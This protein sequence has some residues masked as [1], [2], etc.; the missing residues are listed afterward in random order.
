MKTSSLTFLFLFL[1]YHLYLPQINI[2]GQPKEGFEERIISAVNEIRIIDTHEH[3]PTEEERLQ[4]PQSIDF[5]FLFRHYAKE[6]LISAINDKSF[7]E[8][9]YRT[10]FSL[11]DR[12]ELFSPLYES[13]GNTSYLKVAQIAARDLFGVP[14]ISGETIEDLSIKMKNANKPGWYEKVLKDK[15]KI[16]LSIM[17]MG[18]K[19]FDNNYYRHVERFDQYIQISSKAE[20]FGYGNQQNISVNNLS[21]YEI[22][23][24]KYFE[25]GIE[26]GM[27]GVK[28]GLAYS[29]I[30]RFNNVPKIK[31]EVIFNKLLDGSLINQEEIKTL[32]DYLMHSVLK[33]VDEY[34]IPIQI[35]TG[36]QAGNG[37]TIT[38]SNPTHLSNLFMEYP[39]IDFCLFHG[40]Y[41]YGGELSTLAKNFPNVF[42]DMCWIYVIS[43]SYSERYLHEWLETVPVSKIMAFGGDYNFVEGVYAHSVMAREIVSNV[44][45]E[46]VRTGYF[47]EEEAVRA[48]VKILRDNA[49]RI[50]KIEG[51]SKPLDDLKIFN[52][53]GPIRDWWQI[54]NSGEG[55]VRNWKVI[56][57]FE[58]GNGLDTEYP[59]EEEIIFEK[60]YNGLVEGV[61]WN[62]E[63]IPE[64]GYLN[65]I[66]VFSR[67]YENIN[68]RSKGIA[69]AY[70]EIV[71][72]DE[73]EVKIT[74]G[75]NDG[76]KIWVNGK[77]VYNLHVG[78]N[79]VPDQDVLNV[80]LKKGRNKFLIKVENLG[81]NWGLFLR[82]IDPKKALEF[83]NF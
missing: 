71:S 54:H 38:N 81:A 44:L 31:A 63:V 72:P 1:S 75:S 47:S 26:Y 41:P 48:A 80:N 13:A 70:T 49:L 24:R 3:L 55:F 65:F 82:I 60:T 8:L 22:V 59:V 43:P 21:D 29:R 27:V 79:A 58:Y 56:G 6:D 20:V 46:K 50:F 77:I 73:R 5:S 10:D 30:L 52:K 74:L 62:T 32:Q 19:R 7:V 61:Y 2:S 39:E 17:D 4:N 69:Y 66:S 12:W 14:E 42:I 51:H 64:S 9:F 67:M 33:L 68:P 11:S 37:N 35:H 34:D 40:G 23:I 76:A 16:D 57:P 25:E 53:P 18:H 78:R 36:L 45:I 28:S 83:V 15:A